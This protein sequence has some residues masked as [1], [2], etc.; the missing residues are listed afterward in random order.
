MFDLP[1]Q[2]LVV[3]SPAV[4]EAMGAVFVPPSFDVVL[5]PAGRCYEAWLDCPAAASP[6]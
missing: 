2:M 5:L 4:A 1:E 6:L 3:E